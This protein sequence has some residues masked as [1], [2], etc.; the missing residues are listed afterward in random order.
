MMTCK[1]R[2][3]GLNNCSFVVF[4]EGAAN[5]IIPTTMDRKKTHFDSAI[6]NF[7]NLMIKQTEGILFIYQDLLSQPSCLT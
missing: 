7:N 3:F 4:C 6:W 1:K 2:H 5:S